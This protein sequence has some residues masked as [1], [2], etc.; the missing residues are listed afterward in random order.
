MKRHKSELPNLRRFRLSHFLIAIGVLYLIFI[1]C[2]FPQFLKIVSQLSGD[3]SYAALDETA[4]GGY[5]DADLSKPLF[6]SVYKDVFHRSLEDNEDQDAPSRPN[7]EP[8]K[9]A[10]ENVKQIPQRYGRIIGEILR[11]RNRTN[12]L[13][14]GGSSII[15]G[16]PEVIISE[17]K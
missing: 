1:S 2:K 9:D 16:K 11:R 5:N 8:M 10:L 17:S 4:V 7:K 6:S 15:E 3:K 14:H 13:S 12:D